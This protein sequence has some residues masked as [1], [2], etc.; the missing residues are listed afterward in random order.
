MREKK[1]TPGPWQTM[2]AHNV[3]G[4]K[5]G[6]SG[7]GMRCDD[8][9]AWMVADAGDS[10]AC[11]DGELMELGYGTRKANAKLISAAPDLVEALETC[12]SVLLAD[13]A[14]SDSFPVEQARAA[15]AR[16]YGEQ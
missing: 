7:D 9:D 1:W 11:V 12:L 13:G 14:M 16:A 6:D 10:V 3:F 15:L 2:N 4:P 8:N 5:G